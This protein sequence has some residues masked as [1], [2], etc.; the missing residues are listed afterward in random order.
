LIS[1]VRDLFHVAVPLWDLFVNPTVA[2]LALAI[3]EKQAERV[4]PAVLD[5]LFSGLETSAGETGPK[6]R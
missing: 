6:G 5:R 3:A 4:A 2:G 1:R